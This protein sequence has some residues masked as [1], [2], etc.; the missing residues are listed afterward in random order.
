MRMPSGQPG[1]AV[2][3]TGSGALEAGPPSSADSA[4]SS[5]SSGAGS[6]RSPAGS[7]MVEVSTS[8]GAVLDRIGLRSGYGLASP[9]RAQVARVTE[10]S[11]SRSEGS[12][13]RDPPG[14]A[15]RNVGQSSML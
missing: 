15:F 6:S 9:E 4:A 5:P 2:S 10:L 12:S 14:G 11:P 13:C 1:G 8:Q 7:A 3:G